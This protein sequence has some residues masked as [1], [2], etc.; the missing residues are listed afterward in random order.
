[1]KDPSPAT[2]YFEKWNNPA[3]KD[4]YIGADKILTFVCLKSGGVIKVKGNVL[5]GVQLVNFTSVRGSNEQ[6]K[7][8]IGDKNKDIIFYGSLACNR[9]MLNKAL[10]EFG[11]L[12]S[13]DSE[14]DAPFFFYPPVMATQTPPLAVQIRD[15]MD[16]Y[17][18]TSSGV[19]N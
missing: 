6:I 12:K 18:L 13:C 5:L 1:M 9:L 14:L 7:W 8:D 3:E 16:S 2:K 15:N 4:T 10:E 17:E 11:K 19:S